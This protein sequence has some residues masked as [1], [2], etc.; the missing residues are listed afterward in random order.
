M[1]IGER[2]RAERKRRNWTQRQLGDASGGLSV[3][4]ISEVE[5]GLTQPSLKALLAIAAALEMAA[6]D[7]IGGEC[8][9]VAHL[10]EENRRLRA[11]LESIGRALCDE[12]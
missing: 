9:R 10:E 1:T 5:R 4:Y 2:L 7:F 8:S 3:N 11:R 6:G 12:D